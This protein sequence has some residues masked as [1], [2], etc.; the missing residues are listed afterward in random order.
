MITA[1][2]L[3]YDITFQRIYVTL[4]AFFVSNSFNNKY[5]MYYVFD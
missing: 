1:L 2:S 4:K 3:W 5:E